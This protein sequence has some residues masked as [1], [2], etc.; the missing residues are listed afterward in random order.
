MWKLNEHHVMSQ[1]CHRP[2]G[3]T[4]VT[5]GTWEIRSHI[6]AIVKPFTTDSEP[7]NLFCMQT[8]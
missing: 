1:A 6:M 7:R 2:D 8:P 3:I 4:C 5:Q